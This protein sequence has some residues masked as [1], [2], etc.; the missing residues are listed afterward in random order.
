MI[1]WYEDNSMEIVQTIDDSDDAAT[2]TA[3]ILDAEGEEVWT[4]TL[5]PTETADEYSATVHPADADL[6]TGTRYR[7]RIEATYGG[8]TL[9]FEEVFRPRVRRGA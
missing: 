5:A 3:T 7:L 4:D 1:V 8:A 2:V 6:V 9:E